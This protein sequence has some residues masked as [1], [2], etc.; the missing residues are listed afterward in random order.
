[1]IRVHVAGERLPVWLITTRTHWR[2]GLAAR[3]E[4]RAISLPRAARPWCGCD[5]GVRA[6]PD[7]C[8]EGARELWRSFPGQAAAAE[9]PPGAE[10]L[11]GDVDQ[12]LRV[13]AGDDVPDR[14]RPLG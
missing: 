3:L 2:G 11:Q 4:T 12:A 10:P 7:P 6:G 14:S 5:A 9:R 8:H 13:G 1:M